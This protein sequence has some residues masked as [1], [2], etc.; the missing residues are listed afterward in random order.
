VAGRWIAPLLPQPAPAWALVHAGLDAE[1]DLDAVML[2]RCVGRLDIFDPTLMTAPSISRAR[3]RAAP[4]QGTVPCHPTALALKDE[5]CDAVVVAFTAHEVRD[6]RAR[7]RFFDELRRAI[8]PGGR[9]VLLEHVRDVANFLA[10]GPGCLHFQPRRE[11]LRLAAR[12]HLQVAVERRVTPFVMAL[13]L[14]RVA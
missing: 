12:S 1:V 11:W 3:G 2:G 13:S 5:T 8:R 14:E 6:R 7:E 4:R 9:V 10:F